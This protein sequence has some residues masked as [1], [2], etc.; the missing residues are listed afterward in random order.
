MPV[1]PQVQDAEERDG[2]PPIGREWYSCGGPTGAARVPCWP[3]LED[4]RAVLDDPKRWPGHLC[5]PMLYKSTLQWA[6]EHSGLSRRDLQPDYD[7]RA[8]R[9]L[10]SFPGV[11]E[12]CLGPRYG[13]SPGWWAPC[14]PLPVGREALR[15]SDRAPNDD[16]ILHFRAGMPFDGD[17]EALMV[18]R[19][20]LA[21]AALD[22]FLLGEWG[23]RTAE[24][25]IL[26]IGKLKWQVRGE[27]DAA[28]RAVSHTVQQARRWLAPFQGHRVGAG[29][30]RGTGYFRNADEFDQALRVAVIALRDQ[31]RHL[32][33]ENVAAYFSRS[34]GPVHLDCTDRQLR[35]WLRQFHPGCTW[36]QVREQVTS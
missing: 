30:P 27:T 21:R 9:A 36:E 7:Q 31:R 29:R 6:S 22:L 3:L 35:K 14:W 17:E 11:A 18:L 19:I 26:Y 16:T 28:L 2:A 34:S 10:A 8:Q 25:E 24:S 33:Q 5:N 4:P 20:P 23:E 13:P 12:L 1:D 15:A 32:T